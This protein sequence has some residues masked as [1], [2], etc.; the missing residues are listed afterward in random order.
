M[1]LSDASDVCVSFEV[2]LMVAPRNV[3]VPALLMV[4]FCM[5]K[6]GCVGG[7]GV[8]ELIGYLHRFCAFKSNL[9]SIVKLI[10]IF[11]SS[12]GGVICKL[13]EFYRVIP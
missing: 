10:P 8:P 4:A 1:L 5:T 2:L 7:G 13:E 11:L 3:T 9:F 6:G 12:Q